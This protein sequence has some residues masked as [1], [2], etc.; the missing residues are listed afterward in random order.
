M[1]DSG[2]SRPADR[3]CGVSVG[4]GFRAGIDLRNLQRAMAGLVA[5]HLTRAKGG[6]GGYRLALFVPPVAARLNIPTWSPGVLDVDL[7]LMATPEDTFTETGAVMGFSCSILFLG[8][9]IGNRPLI[10]MAMCC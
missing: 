7:A 1:S 10:R 8:Q 6:I 3:Y 5:G 4:R 9:M 2:Q